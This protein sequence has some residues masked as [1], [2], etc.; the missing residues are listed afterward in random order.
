MF[1]AIETSNVQDIKSKTSNFCDYRNDNLPRAQDAI[2]RLGKISHIV[3]LF[4][5]LSPRLNQFLH[6][7]TTPHAEFTIFVSIVYYITL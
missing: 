3:A 2:H 1:H 4:S 6:T 7:E 5:Y